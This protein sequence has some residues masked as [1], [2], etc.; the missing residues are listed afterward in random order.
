VIRRAMLAAAALSLLS[1]GCAPAPPGN[2]VVV[3]N[4][5]RRGVDSIVV[6]PDPPR[7][8]AITARHGYLAPSDSARVP[9]PRGRG[10]VDVRIWRDGRVVA[11]H[12][13]YF[14]GQSVFEV[15]VGDTAQAGRYRKTR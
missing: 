3:L 11:D 2:A 5:G 14:G 10:D 7:A 1:S 13:A 9:L 4:A 6:E 8:H 15:R 12:V